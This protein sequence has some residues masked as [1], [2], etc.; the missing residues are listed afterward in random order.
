[1]DLKQV[2]EH[3]R[4]GEIT[5]QRT[6]RARRLS[7]SVRPPAKVRLTL[8]MEVPVKEGMDFLAEK[9]DWIAAALAKVAEKYPVRTIEQGYRTPQR[10]LSYVPAAGDTMQARISDGHIRVVHPERMRYDD[11]EV[12]GLARR[13]VIKALKLEA[14]QILPPLVEEIAVKHGF[15]YG[16]VTVRET[17]SRW[18]SCS[19][20]NNISLSIF[21]LCVPR[22]LCEYVI[23]HELCHTKYK[24]HSPAFHR[25]LDS[26]LG[27]K[28][29]EFVRE[30]HEY[31]TDVL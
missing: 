7:V 3:P 12:Q 2:I 6:R 22:H 25:L 16:K 20:E 21:L 14:K 30:L 1:M 8:P 5:V 11:P 29:K 13:A 24:D 4:L 26:I 27:G 23:L 17:T 18:G 15:R 9:E 19:H 10:E 31:R 28:E